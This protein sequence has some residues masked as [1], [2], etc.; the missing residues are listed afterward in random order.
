METKEIKIAKAK[1][2]VIA[3]AA[4]EQARY[5]SMFINWFKGLVLMFFIHYILIAIIMFSNRITRLLNSS[6]ENAFD[7][8][9]AI[10]KKVRTDTLTTA[11]FAL[12]PVSLNTY[13]TQHPLYNAILYIFLIITYLKFFKMYF[14]SEMK[15]FFVTFH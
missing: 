11:L 13:G 5:K 15:Y 8:G 2:V 14:W 10:E 1:T 7:N 9:I 12:S 3:T 6:I 4:E